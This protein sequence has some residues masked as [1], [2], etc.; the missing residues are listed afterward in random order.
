MLSRSTKLRMRRRFRRRKLQVEEFGQQAGNQLEYNF[1]RRLERLANVR[2]FVIT[3]VL[4]VVLLGASVVGQIV[5]MKGYYQQ[6][7]PVAGGTYNEGILGSFTDANPLFASTPADLAV[8]KLVFSGLLT[9]D[10]KN[11][12]TGDIAKDWKVDETGT[13]Y[14]VN[15][16]PNIKWHDGKPLTAKDVLFTYQTIQKP[17]AKS[18]LAPSWRGVKIESVNNLVVKFTLPSPLA[19]FPYSLTNGV[20]PEHLLGGV[21]PEALRSQRFNVEP[22]GCGP[23]RFKAVEVIGGSPDNRQE[24]VGLERYEGY[25]RGTPKLQ[26][27]VLKTFRSER[28]LVKSF[29]DKDINA[30][31]GLT[32]VPE[33]LYEDKSV[34]INSLPLEAAVM[35]FFRTNA[36]ILSDVAVRRALVSAT[37]RQ[38]LIKS[39]GYYTR[40]VESPI[41]FGQLGYDKDTTQLPYDPVA[42]N[43]YLTDAGWV[44]SGNDVRSKASTKLKFSI[45]V[46]KDTE[47][48]QIAQDLARQWRKVGVDVSVVPQDVTDFQ[49]TLLNHDYDVLLYGISIGKDPD[50]LVYWDSKYADIRAENRLNFSEYKSEAADASLQA[51]RTRL[52]ANLRTI[53]YKPFLQAWRSD[54]PAVGLY[55]PRFLYITHGPVYGLQERSISS[56]VE[57]FSDVHLW[58]I[59]EKGVSQLAS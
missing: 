1:F 37:D 17:D 42:A 27:F 20:V 44:H 38:S 40:A 24:N 6:I 54:A 5:A 50:V 2:R 15:L 18:P 26:R 11:K 22:I 29:T 36:E 45:T 16:K 3:W 34:R 35:A 59:R 25:H 47:Y 57:R 53:K 9:Y 49:S 51:G 41:L 58:M 19:S 52:D 46:Q 4:L 55:Q 56:G 43:K 23:F 13:I 31:A 21:D 8:A 32:Q 39:L 33:E 28:A 14:T 7:S 48:G 30:I 10:Q 12:L